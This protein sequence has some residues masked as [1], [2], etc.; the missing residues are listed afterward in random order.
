MPNIFV[1]IFYNLFFVAPA[2]LAL[3]LFGRFSPKIKKNLHARKGW[4][5]SLVKSVSALGKGKRVLFHVASAGELQQ[6]LPLIQ[7]MKKEN[8]EYSIGISFYSISGYSFFK[9]DPAVDFICYMPF[10]TPRNSSFFMSSVKPDIYV[11]VT[12]DAWLNHCVAAKNVG[13]SL[14][15]ISG[16]LS[17]ESSRIRFPLRAV[18][19]QT[20]AL[21]DAIFTIADEDKSEMIKLLG[22]DSAIFVAGDPRYDHILNGIAGAED[23][24]LE[25]GLPRWEGERVMTLG[26]L[27]EPGWEIIGSSILAEVAAQKLRLFVAPH[28]MHE[29][30]LTKIE[31]ECEALEIPVIRF[32]DLADV[33]N[34]EEYRVVIVN[35]VGLL[36][37]LYSRSSLAY[38]GGAFGKGVHNVAEP[39]AFGLPLYFGGNYS[40]SLEA[41]RAVETGAAVVV[42]ESSAFGEDLR[43]LLSDSEEFTKRSEKASAVVH[44]NAGATSTIYAGLAE[45]KL[46][47]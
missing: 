8:P 23:R 31:R 37:A 40:R 14:V 1:M 5:Q 18:T 17:S 28:E 45:L 34:V 3:K 12:Y 33:E 21:F 42:E 22:D 44:S 9:G 32:S 30:L 38:V 46:I 15:M 20:L 47:S 36:A 29:E 26:S 4:E 43:V 25:T 7:Q 35:T 2:E 11:V 19:K 27:W 16:N 10:D 13:A 24:L 41:R 39:A 6:A